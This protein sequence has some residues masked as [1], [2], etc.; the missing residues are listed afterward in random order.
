MVDAVGVHDGRGAVVL[1]APDPY[2]GGQVG[3]LTFRKSRTQ[4]AFHNGRQ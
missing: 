1:D 3:P 4:R 2:G